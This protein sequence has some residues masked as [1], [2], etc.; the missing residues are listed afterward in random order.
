A[1]G[2]IDGVVAPADTIKSLHF[3]EVAKHFTTIRFSRGAYPARAIS[4]A[5]WRRLPPDMQAL[6]IRSK[7][8]WETALNRQLQAA[9]I[10][11]IVFGKSNGVNFRPLPGAEQARFDALYNADA[12]RQ[13]RGM[14][15]IGID[16]E[17]VLAAAQAMIK[18][19]APRHCATT[20]AQETNS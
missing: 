8:A 13:A 16:A 18:A 5:A 1:K 2:V 19:G 17:P 9:E 3:S 20:G 11:G 14:Q 15:T 7:P 10:A 6:L 4:D 12:T